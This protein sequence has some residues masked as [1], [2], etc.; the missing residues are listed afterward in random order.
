MEM[1]IPDL[2]TKT[3]EEQKVFAIKNTCIEEQVLER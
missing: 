2:I 1:F 3:I